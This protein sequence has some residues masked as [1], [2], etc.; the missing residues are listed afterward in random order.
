MKS[1]PCAK[2]TTSMMPKISVSPD[3][4]SARIMP[5]TT[6][7]MVWIR[8]CSIGMC[9]S[10]TQVLVNYRVADAELRRPGVVADDAF[11]DEIDPLAGF[12]GQRHVLLDEE[13]RDA[14]LVQHI[15]DRADLADHARHQP[16]GRFVEKDDLGLQHHRPGDRQHLL[17]APR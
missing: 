14:V 5:V 11:L 2:L 17:L 15:D 3:E 1:S 12:Q 7:L 16:L 9:M 10:D 6:P 13:H 8:I 4:T